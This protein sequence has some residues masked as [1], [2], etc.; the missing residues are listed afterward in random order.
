MKSNNQKVPKQAEAKMDGVITHNITISI[1]FK[2]GKFWC[3]PNATNQPESTVEL[4]YMCPR[5]SLVHQ[6]WH[7]PS[8]WNSNRDF[9]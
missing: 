1:N 6:Q 7:S 4:G 2:H 5:D 8:S 3:S 9:Y